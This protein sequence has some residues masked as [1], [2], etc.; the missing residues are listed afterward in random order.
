MPRTPKTQ[1]HIIQPPPPSWWKKS[2]HKV[3]LVAGV[4]AG[5]WIGTHP[6]AGHADPAHATTPPASCSAGARTG[7]GRQ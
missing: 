5:L 3:L 1:Y 7:G 6:L 2:R 4:V